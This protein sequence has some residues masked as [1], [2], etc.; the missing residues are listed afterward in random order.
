LALA[1]LSQNASESHSGP[2]LQRRKRSLMAVLE[3]LKPSD[4][5]AI[6]VFDDHLQALDVRPIGF[7]AYRVLQLV[8]TLPPRPSLPSL[9][10]VAQKVKATLPVSVCDSRLCRV[11]RQSGLHRPLPHLLQRFFGFR[12]A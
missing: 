12:L 6:D 1:P 11:Q 5:R 4:Q 2:S 10:V 9:E 7:S 8:Q 3:V